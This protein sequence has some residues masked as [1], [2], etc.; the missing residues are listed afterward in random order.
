MTDNPRVIVLGGANGAGKT[1]S[2]RKL[3][4]E[5]LAVMSFVNA[6]AIA[7]GLSG[8]DPDASAITA[9]RIMLERLDELATARADFAFETTLSGRSYAPFLRQLKANGYE[10]W[11]Y[12]F[13][14]NSPD[15][16]VERVAL[17]V[18]SGGHHIPEATIRQRYRRSVR[19]F[20]NLYRPLADRWEVHDN[21][22]ANLVHLI[23]ESSP[24]GENVIDAPTW[25]K[26]LRSAADE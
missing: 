10:V 19:N 14:L 16:N 20:L 12:Y 1:T 21:S 17:R 9:G 2:S 5:M 13:W 25:A 6:D 11:L 4:A 23:A 22:D 8:F 15:L 3:L 18:Q 7:V 26:F 24:D